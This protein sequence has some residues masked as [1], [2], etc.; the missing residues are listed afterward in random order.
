MSC[1]LAGTAAKDCEVGDVPKPTAITLDEGVPAEPCNVHGNDANS[2]TTEVPH[3]I[4]TTE[5]DTERTHYT[6][7]EWLTNGYFPGP[8]SPTQGTPG[9][10]SQCEMMNMF[11]S[12]PGPEFP[13]QVGIVQDPCGRAYDG[14]NIKADNGKWIKTESGRACCL[15]SPDVPGQYYQQRCHCKSN[16]LPDGGCQQACKD[17]PGCLGWAANKGDG[18]CDWATRSKSC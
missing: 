8:V 1:V 14:C 12:G 2:P 16:E 18:A 15:A 3:D 17:D 11:S 10:G 4:P 5:P 6:A 7:A 13:I 9:I